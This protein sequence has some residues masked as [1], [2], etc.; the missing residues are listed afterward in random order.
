MIAV[1]LTAVSIIGCSSEVSTKPAQ[2]TLTPTPTPQLA[3]TPT[4]PKGSLENPAELGETLVVKTLSGTFEITVLDYLRGYQANQKVLQANMFNEKPEKG[5]EY[6]LVKV[7]LKYAEGRGSVKEGASSFKVFVEGEGFDPEIIVWPAGMKDMDILKDLLPGGKTE[8]WIAFIV[9]QGKGALLSYNYLL[10]PVGFIKLGSTSSAPQATTTPTSTSNPMQTPEQAVTP[11]LKM[12]ES[13]KTSNLNITVKAVKTNVVA[14]D[15]GNYWAEENCIFIVAAVRVENIGSEKEYIS[16]SD[17]WLTDDS[18]KRYDREVWS[19]GSSE[20]YPGEYRDLM[21]GFEVPKN[22]QKVYVKYSSGFSEVSLA[23][24]ESEAGELKLMEAKIK[25]E[26]GKI[27]SESAYKAIA[28]RK[29]IFYATNEGNWPIYLGKVE[30]KFGGNP[31][32]YLGS[33]NEIIK[34]GEKKTIELST[35]RT[36]TTTPSIKVRFVDDDHIIAE[37][38]SL[39]HI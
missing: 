26:R 39:I 29:V 6:L 20:L 5:Y 7:R 19:S 32:G 33:V 21:I 24:W 31:W 27:E 11:K 17:F 4:P 9:P 30:A 37:G 34:P 38:L 25:I 23:V 36:F 15:F 14:R 10:Q 1:I 8:G 18:G 3:T 13:F 12:G 22:A 16:T 35:Y 2:E 28:I